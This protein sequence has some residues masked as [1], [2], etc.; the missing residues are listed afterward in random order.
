MLVKIETTYLQLIQAPGS[1]P[2][3]LLSTGPEAIQTTLRADVVWKMISDH[4]PECSMGSSVLRG[5]ARIMVVD[6]CHFSVALLTLV[7]S[8][9]GVRADDV[10]FNVC[11][12]L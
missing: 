7:S 12:S 11:R 6:T 3:I 10:C 8:K 1:S 5:M 9:R 2:R 4:R